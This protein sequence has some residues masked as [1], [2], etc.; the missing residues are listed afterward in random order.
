M[1]FREHGVEGD[2]KVGVRSQK[3]EHVVIYELDIWQSR[4]RRKTEQMIEM[5]LQ[6]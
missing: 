4:K 1:K 6:T 3:L 2:R 5:L